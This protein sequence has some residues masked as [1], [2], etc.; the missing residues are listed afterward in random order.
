VR[1]DLFI[2]SREDGHPSAAR[3]FIDPIS[4]IE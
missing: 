2:T 4:I 3:E 1:A